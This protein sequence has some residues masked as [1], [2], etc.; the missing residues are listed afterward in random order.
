MAEASLRIQQF[1][2]QKKTHLDLSGLGLIVMPQEVYGLE[3]LKGLDLSNNKLSS[4]DSKLGSLASL[5]ELILDSNNLKTL[6]QEL[7]KLKGLTVLSVKGNPLSSSFTALLSCPASSLMTTLSAC[8]KKQ[9]ESENDNLFDDEWDDPVPAS[10]HKLSDDDFGFESEHMSKQAKKPVAKNA[11]DFLGSQPKAPERRKQDKDDFGFDGLLDNLSMTKGTKSTVFA[12]DD[13]EIGIEEV[14]IGPKISQGGY[15][16]VAK[17]SFRGTEVAVKKIFDPVITDKLREEMDT[18]I[19]M[20]TKLRHPHIVLMMGFSRKAPNLFI[21]FELLKRGSLFDLLH[22]SK[23]KVSDAQKLKISLQI[24][25]ALQY[26][27]M[28]KIVHR[29]I[30][31]LNIL[32]DENLNAKLCDFGIAKKFVARVY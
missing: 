17:G 4:L 14:N 1:K 21:I 22:R 19:T 32:L 13:E 11:S 28:S 6:P 30:K 8:L 31:S 29:D 26:I 23:D 24:A 18:E 10:K 27:H 7:G 16:I 9:K 12:D 25:K 2:R 5:Q 3:G 15:S 20:L